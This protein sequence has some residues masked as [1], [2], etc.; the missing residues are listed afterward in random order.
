MFSS[1]FITPHQRAIAYMLLSTAGFSAMSV[2]V[3]FIATGMDAAVIV[4]WRNFIT[5]LL[6][7]PWALPKGGALL[8]TKRLG[9][10]AWRGAVALAVAG[11]RA[12]KDL[13]LLV[14]ACAIAARQHRGQMR[15]GGHRLR[16]GHGED[17]TPTS[18]DRKSVV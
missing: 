2:G 5:L 1:I 11:L 14:E 8:K 17:G 18:L 6:L 13:P 10:H 7:L 4:T 3:R 9:G 15:A 16:G 12:V